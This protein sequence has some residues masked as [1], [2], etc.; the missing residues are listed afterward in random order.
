MK[1]KHFTTPDQVKLAYFDKGRGTPVILIAGY[2]APATSWYAQEKSLLRA[3]YRVIGFDRRSHGGSDNPPVGQDM[4]THGRDLAALLDHLQLEK[5]FLI[6]QS[7]GAS[8]V[9]AYISQFGSDRL[10]GLISIDQTPKMLN[11]ADWPHGMVG[12]N[13]ESRPTYFDNPLPKP[14]KKRPKLLIV[15]MMLA[16][17]TKYLKFDREG[18]KPLLLDHADADWRE[19]IRKTDVPALFVAGAESP[20]WPASHAAAGAALCHRGE[21]AVIEGSGHAVNWECPAEFDRLMLDFLARHSS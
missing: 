4:A 19:T 21:V 8:T 16:R 7:Q 6:G 9:W 13:A 11:T 18:T 2:S 5:V 3:G 14:N 20:F 12:L 17:G 15:L 1:L 10:H